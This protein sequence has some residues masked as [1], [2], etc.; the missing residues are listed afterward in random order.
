MNK[1]CAF[2]ALYLIPYAAYAS[3]AMGAEISYIYIGNQQLEVTYTFYRDCAGIAAP[4]TISLTAI[5]D[6]GINSASYT[7][8]PTATSPV[9]IHT[10][11]AGQVT[12]CNGGPYRGVEK[13]VYTGVINLMTEGMIIY[14]SE[15]AR[16]S[17]LNTITTGGDLFVYARIINPS[18]FNN[19]SPVFNMNPEITLCTN[20]NYCLPTYVSDADGDS[21][22]FQMIAPRTGPNAYDTISY[23]TGYSSLQ[24]FNSSSPVSFDS[25]NG[26]FCITP[27]ASGETSPMA[28]LVSEYRNGVLIGQ[29]ERD[30]QIAIEAC[31]NQIPQLSGLNGVPLTTINVCSGL[32]NCFFITATDNDSTNTTFVNWDLTLPYS[33]TSHTLGKRDTLFICWVPADS[34]TISA[35]CFNASVLDNNCPYPSTTYASFCLNV[36]PEHICNPTASINDEGIDANF[37]IFPQPASD[38]INFEFKT[39]DADR[40]LQI[41]S[42]IGSLI[43]DITVNEKTLRLSL[44]GY[45]NGIYFVRITSRKNVMNTGKFIVTK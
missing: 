44:A 16:S 18:G 43:K 20:T 34:D 13:W 42:I 6:S 35:R 40:T 31:I 30:M 14:H 19:S 21:L 5:S 1:I 2:I 26:T 8:T 33:I 38:E 36:I 39:I 28:I 45:L 11:C 10:V 27:S 23:L 4:S 37:K 15:N 25:S 3:H 29:V 22:S 41:Y 12:T 32:Q 7:L 17:Q 24:P 9:Y